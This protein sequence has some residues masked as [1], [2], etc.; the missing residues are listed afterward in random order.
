M[1]FNEKESPGVYAV[2][3]VNNPAMQGLFIALKEQYKD[4]ELKFSTIDKEQ[5]ILL[6]VALIPDKPIYRNVQGREFN[7]IFKAETIKDIAHNF[8]KKGYQLNSSIEHEGDP[9]KGVSVVES[10]IVDDPQK[11]KAATYG[12]EYPA[13]SWV[14]SMKVDNPEIWADYVKTGKVK[15]F[16]IDGLFDLK[17][18]ELKTE[19]K[20]KGPEKKDNRSTLSSLF[21]G[22]ATLLGGH[23]DS[24]GKFAV[25]L[26][27]VK[28][29]EGDT[30]IFFEGD[31]LSV[32][33]RVYLQTAE[34]ERTP[35]PV[36]EY[37]LESGMIL[38]VTEEG[39]VGELREAAEVI[40]ELP[41]EL[42]D[43]IKEFMAS[44]T[45]HAEGVINT[46]KEENERLK[47][48]N[49]SLKLKADNKPGAKKIGLKADET[50][51]P[52]RPVYRHPNGLNHNTAEEV[53]RR[54]RG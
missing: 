23:V 30:E 54:L 34:G 38:V 25:E 41:A 2:S 5:R 1:I 39:V 11:D 47:A 13:G 9:I 53:R 8:L 43:A 27:S 28:V 48:E 50:K 20:M 6:G 4:A 44:M 3:L 49:A 7:I 19:I 22:I 10:W 37:P 32:G 40:E 29:A 35:L 14:I 15:G 51:R 21:S 31:A 52:E 18:I 33:G 17:K 16:S 36:G 46:L 42:S 26:A 45:S 12:M 24:D